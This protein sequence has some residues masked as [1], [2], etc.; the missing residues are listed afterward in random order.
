[1]T[2]AGGASESRKPLP[3]GAS[4]S[5]LG[6][7]PP[8]PG[9]SFLLWGP[10]PPRVCPPRRSHGLFL[11]ATRR[12]R[13]RKG[14]SLALVCQRPHRRGWA[15]ARG[16]TLDLPA[17]VTLLWTSN[18]TFPPA[19]GP[20]QREP[21]WWQSSIRGSTASATSPSATTDTLLGTGPRSASGAS[22]C[23]HDLRFLTWAGSQ[24]QRRCGMSRGSSGC[25][26][27]DFL[28]PALEFWA[29]PVTKGEDE[30]EALPF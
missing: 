26:R 23:A 24:L 25:I 2:E 17:N 4:L 3:L 13:G 16:W 19:R 20:S 22:V 29:L 12:A 28:S 21:G 8:R 9:A 5:G 27:S 30:G 15:C 6:A 10:V 7:P 14:Q 18:S 1:M 11:N